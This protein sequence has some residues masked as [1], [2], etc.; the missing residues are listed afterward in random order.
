MG[1]TISI[2]SVAADKFAFPAYHAA[3]SG[4]RDIADAGGFE[5]ALGE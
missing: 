3:P 2:T 4:E 1:E 5:A